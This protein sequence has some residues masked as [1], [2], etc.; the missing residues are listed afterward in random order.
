MHTSLAEANR[1]KRIKANEF[2]EKMC[3]F[4]TSLIGSKILDSR[5]I[6]KTYCKN[7]LSDLLFFLGLE[8]SLSKNELDLVIT[9]SYRKLFN[10]REYF[11][12]N[13]S[14]GMFDVGKKYFFRYATDPLAYLF[15]KS[16][17]ASEIFFKNY[18]PGW[19]SYWNKNTKKNVDIIKIVRHAHNG[20]KIKFLPNFSGSGTK[21]SLVK[22]YG[23]DFNFLDSCELSNIELLA[24]VVPKILAKKVEQKNE[25]GI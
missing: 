12:Y 4:L 25:L 19:N 10:S 24:Y 2:Q 8:T 17:E 11:E 9:L 20:S 18:T 3:L 5:I 21:I 15:L 13:F 6:H 1:Q 16:K 22:E 14:S 7:T 23:I